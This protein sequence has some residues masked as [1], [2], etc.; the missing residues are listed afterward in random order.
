M[1]RSLVILKQFWRVHLDTDV[2]YHMTVLNCAGVVQ[3]TPDWK[4]FVVENH[5][6]HHVRRI[7]ER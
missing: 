6:S 5:H 3:I 2:G 4:A 1:I 7:L